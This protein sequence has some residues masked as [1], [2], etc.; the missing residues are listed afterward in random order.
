MVPQPLMVGM[1]QPSYTPCCSLSHELTE[2][3]RGH[4]PPSFFLKPFS[5][6][7]SLQCCWGRGCA[8]SGTPE[9]S[10]QREL[11]AGFVLPFCQLPGL[12]CQPWQAG[13]VPRGLGSQDCFSWAGLGWAGWDIVKDQSWACSTTATQL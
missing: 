11:N 8:P 10:L 3:H 2:S 12:L 5:S 13:T 1:P 9:V 6:P 7:F 4:Q